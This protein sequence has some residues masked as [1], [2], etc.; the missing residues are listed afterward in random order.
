MEEEI[1][2]LRCKGKDDEGRHE[3]WSSIDLRGEVIINRIRS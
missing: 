2:S 3:D 1:R